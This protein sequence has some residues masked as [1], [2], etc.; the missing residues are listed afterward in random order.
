MDM[1]TKIIL[2]VFAVICMGLMV[3]PVYDWFMG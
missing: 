3:D 2:F 1:D